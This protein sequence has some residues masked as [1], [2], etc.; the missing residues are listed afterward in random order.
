MPKNV[1]YV[2]VAVREDLRKH[3]GIAEAAFRINKSPKQLGREIRGETKLGII[4]LE[5]VADLRK[6]NLIEAET[7]ETW[8]PS[9]RQM[10]QF[11]QTEKEKPRYV[12]RRTFKS[13]IPF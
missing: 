6:A 8:W 7:A 11:K 1:P 3:G 9:A 5:T 13:S 10:L 4:S 2:N 12:N